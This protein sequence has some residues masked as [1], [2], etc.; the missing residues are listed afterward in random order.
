MDLP[1]ELELLQFLIGDDDRIACCNCN[2]AGVTAKQ[3]TSAANF[4][5]AP[6]LQCG[7]SNGNG[8]GKGKGKALWVDNSTDGMVGK[9]GTAGPASGP[10]RLR[11][12]GKRTTVNAVWLFEDGV[13]GWDTYDAPMRSLLEAAYKEGGG[14]GGGEVVVNVCMNLT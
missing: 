13:G 5:D 7:N 11:S 2:G 1:N 14:V 12:L 3:H 6:R 9:G 8:N 4:A 10:A